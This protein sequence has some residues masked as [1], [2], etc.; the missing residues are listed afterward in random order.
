QQAQAIG[1]KAWIGGI[2]RDVIEELVDRCSQLSH[3]GHGGLE[4]LARDRSSRSLL[5]RIYRLG[6]SLFFWSLEQGGI[7]RLVVGPRI[8]LLSNAQEIYGALGT[9]EETLPVLGAEEPSQSLDAPLDCEHTS[10]ADCHH[11]R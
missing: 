3:L 2:D 6:E 9:D 4:V 7:G 10:S 8:L 1:A 11:A 5:N